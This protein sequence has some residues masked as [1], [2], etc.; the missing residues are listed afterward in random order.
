MI[1]DGLTP[2]A[3]RAS[4]T[5]NCSYWCAVGDCSCA[6]G[7]AAMPGASSATSG[8]GR[9]SANASTSSMVFTKRSFIDSAQILR[10]LGEVLLVV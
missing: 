10:H 8:S 3:L 5:V 2:E 4:S 9:S 7:S 1:N 6:G